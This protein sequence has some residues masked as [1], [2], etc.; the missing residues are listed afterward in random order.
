MK[1]V[2]KFFIIA[3]MIGCPLFLNSQVATQPAGYAQ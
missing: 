1:L 2:I 3:A